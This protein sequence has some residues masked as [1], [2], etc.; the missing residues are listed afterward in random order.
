MTDRAKLH[1]WAETT[2]YAA[3]EGGK[4]SPEDGDTCPECGEP[5]REGERVHRVTER[6]DNAWVHDKHVAKEG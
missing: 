2:V 6:A 4:A 3:G 1:G 5:L